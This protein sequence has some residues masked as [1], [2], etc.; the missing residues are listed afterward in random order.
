[1]Y[2]TLARGA[3]ANADRSL[4]GFPPG[5]VRLYFN[6]NTASWYSNSNVLTEPGLPRYAK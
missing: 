5:P 4:T 3:M 6:F 1:M 2:C